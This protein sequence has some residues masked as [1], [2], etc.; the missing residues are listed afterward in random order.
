[1]KESLRLPVFLVLLLIMPVPAYCHGELIF[2]RVFFIFPISMIVISL[3]SILL[4][5][6][7]IV[8]KLGEVENFYDIKS[9]TISEN[10]SYLPVWGLIK[11][12]IKNNLFR[13]SVTLVIFL[14]ISYLIN[15]VFY[16]KFS[17]KLNEREVKIGAFVLSIINVFLV[18]TIFIIY[19][20]LSS[21]TA[22]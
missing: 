3:V 20:I 16:S 11:T 7:Y 14:A 21:S 22:F 4:K 8:E 1:M 6:K 17:D 5:K 10:I 15:W 2:F 19:S 18:S 13:I 9:A 12:L